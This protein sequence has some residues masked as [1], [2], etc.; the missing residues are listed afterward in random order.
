MQTI[1]TK[2]LAPTN[3][4]GARIK[5]QAEWGSKT[6]DY[7]HGAESAH[8]VA[9][10]QFLAERNAMMHEMYPDHGEPWWALVA[11]AESLDHRGNVYIV[12]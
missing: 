8:D 9:F 5:V 1:Q 4:R 10:E 2:Y 12:K 11:A 6:Y 7:D 3:T